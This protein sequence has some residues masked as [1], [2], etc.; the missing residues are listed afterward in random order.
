MTVV[1]INAVKEQQAQIEELKGA[2]QELKSAVCGLIPS[3]AVCG[4]KEK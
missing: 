2:N 4:K 1:L 3:L